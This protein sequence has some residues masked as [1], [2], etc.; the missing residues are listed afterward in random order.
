MVLKKGGRSQIDQWNR[1]ENPETDL[2]VDWNLAYG[3]RGHRKSLGKH[4][5]IS[6]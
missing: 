5:L 4:K 2:G 1:I 3:K 6:S